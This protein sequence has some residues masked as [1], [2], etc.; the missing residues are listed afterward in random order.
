MAQPWREFLCWFD[1]EAPKGKLTE[2][3]A[4]AALETFRR[5]TAR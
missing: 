5:E 3:D 2:I 1:A 4:V